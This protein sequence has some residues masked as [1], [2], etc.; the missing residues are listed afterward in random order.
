MYYVSCNNMGMNYKGLKMKNNH[1][2]LFVMIHKIF[3]HI[4]YIAFVPT[5]IMLKNIGKLTNY[6]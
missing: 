6:F 4:I 1:K 3:V 5:Y 2:L